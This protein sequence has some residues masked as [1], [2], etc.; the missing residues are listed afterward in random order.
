MT[1]STDFALH[2][3]GMRYCGPGTDLDAKLEAD[4]RTP[5]PECKPVDRIDEAALRHDIYY[6]EHPRERDRIAGDDVM[7]QEIREIR[8]TRRPNVT[9]KARAHYSI[10]PIID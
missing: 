3:P 6:R 8:V 7:L 5:K 4:G 2:F 10:S 9:R 1:D